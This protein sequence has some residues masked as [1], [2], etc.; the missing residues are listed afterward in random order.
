MQY[1]FLA[2]TESNGYDNKSISVE[3]FCKLNMQSIWWISL[4]MCGFGAYLGL[5]LHSK[6]II[7]F[8][9]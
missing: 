8:L 6:S 3:S 4:I 9:L 2:I 1:L 5:E 7:L